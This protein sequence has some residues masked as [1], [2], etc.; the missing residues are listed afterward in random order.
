LQKLHYFIDKAEKARDERKRSN[1][2]HTQ[3]R[4][5]ILTGGYSPSPKKMKMFESGTNN[6]KRG[7]A[8]NKPIEKKTIMAR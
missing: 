8:A 6:L 2:R 1:S 4:D 3:I 5:A 7:S